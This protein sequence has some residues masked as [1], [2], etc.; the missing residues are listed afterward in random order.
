MS[1]SQVLGNHTLTTEV[2]NVS[3][4]GVWLF[5]R[6]K[7]IFMSFKDFPWFKGSPIAKIIN[8]QEPSRGH[9]YWPDLDID[10][11]IE[12]I[13]HPERF[14]LK[15]RWFRHSQERIAIR[16]RGTRPIKLA[17]QILQNLLISTQKNFRPSWL[18][19][20]VQWCRISGDTHGHTLYSEFS[21][22]CIRN[23]A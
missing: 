8:V 23:S 16:N 1:N 21:A 2:T 7:E 17:S 19:W 6:G 22:P 18:I 9:F 12:S 14:P 4:H 13:E 3:S 5:T 15:Y 10:L 20:L 11:G